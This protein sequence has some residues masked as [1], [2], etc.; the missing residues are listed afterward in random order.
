MDAALP[1][2]NND[3][4]T[5]NLKY[6][7]YYAILGEYSQNAISFLARRAIETQQWFPTVKTCL[8]I[9]K[10]WDPPTDTNSELV[11]KTRTEIEA[12][13]KQVMIALDEGKMT[14]S[15]FDQLSDRWK[16]IAETKGLVRIDKEGNYFVRTGKIEV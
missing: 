13:F 9:L 4:L 15:E 2:K 8:E 11:R 3:A 5:G 6:A 7:A 1:S 10:D 14:Q 16:Q 12:R